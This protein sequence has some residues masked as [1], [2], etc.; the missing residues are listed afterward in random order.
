MAW[1]TAGSNQSELCAPDPLRQLVLAAL[2][3]TPGCSAPALE[4]EGPPAP[5]ATRVTQVV[6]IR[7]GADLESA[8]H[9]DSLLIEDVAVVDNT[10]GKV[11]EGRAKHERVLFGRSG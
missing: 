3:L 4:G 9:F 10:A 5:Q 7:S 2:L 1:C 6:R 8:H 11:A